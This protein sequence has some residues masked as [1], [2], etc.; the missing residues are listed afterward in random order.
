M[1][2]LGFAPTVCF[3]PKTPKPWCFGKK[4]SN[5]TSS[6]GTWKLMNLLIQRNTKVLVNI[7]LSSW[8]FLQGVKVSDLG[9]GDSWRNV[10]VSPLFQGSQAGIIV[11]AD[12]PGGTQQPGFLFFYCSGGTN[13]W[14]EDQY[15]RN[16][17]AMTFDIWSYLSAFNPASAANTEQSISF[18]TMGDANTWYTLGWIKDLPNDFKVWVIS[19]VMVFLFNCIDSHPEHTNSNFEI[20]QQK[21]RYKQ[22]CF[23]FSTDL[24]YMTSFDILLLTFGTAFPD[25]TLNGV[26]LPSSTLL[27]FQLAPPWDI[28]TSFSWWIERKG[29]LRGYFFIP[30][31]IVLRQNTTNTSG[32]KTELNSRTQAV[33]QI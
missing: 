18:F 1:V 17:L 16:Y 9:G 19:V 20:S 24:C 22:F 23:I 25:D 13:L 11:I 26:I 14:S 30:V 4:W 27:L 33:I 21:W 7:Q 2:S 12:T 32:L 3:A 28:F 31:Q 10:K 29:P 15:K 5:L 8:W 6:T